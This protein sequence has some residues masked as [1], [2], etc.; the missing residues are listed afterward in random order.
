MAG[1]RPSAFDTVEALELAIDN[2]FD[3]DAYVG[4]EYLPT[5]SGLAISIGVDRR[6]IVNY[7]NKEQ[8][9]PT[10]KAARAK[11][12]AFLEQR[13]YG[14]TVT[15]VIFNLKN[16]FGWTDKQEIQ[17]TNVEVSHEDWLKSLE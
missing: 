1:G 5:M 3:V 17:N 14:N 16:N 15:G 9:F 7:S 2:Y 13:L 10:I 6:T 4:E 11:V 8:F 12:E